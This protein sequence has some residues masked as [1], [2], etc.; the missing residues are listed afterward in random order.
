MREEV[1]TLLA[2]L[3]ISLGAA[4]AGQ[5]PAPPC[6][7]CG[8]YYDITR[9]RNPYG[10]VELGW[11]HESGKFAVDIA[12]RH[13]SSIPAGDHGLNSAE[14]RLKWMPWK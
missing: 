14:V 5:T 13:E 11:T 4:Y 6:P 1:S 12:A 2:G 9:V 3:Y 10:I 8:W 7:T